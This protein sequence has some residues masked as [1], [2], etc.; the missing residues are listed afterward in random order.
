MA[1]FLANKESLSSAPA[2][3]VPPSASDDKA[4]AV[5]I[6]S[7]GKTSRFALA[8]SRNEALHSFRALF[9][10]RCFKYDCALH[11]YRSTQ[12]MWSYRWPVTHSANIG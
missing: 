4:S 12:S 11:P 6:S 7:S 2:T 1:A 3:S 5:T 8:P 9:C 10:R